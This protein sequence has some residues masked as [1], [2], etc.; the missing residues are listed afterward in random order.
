MEMRFPGYETVNWTE[1]E[2][3]RKLPE[4]WEYVPLIDVCELTMGQSPKS[5]FYN[6]NNDGLPFH[7]GVTGYGFRY[8]VDSKYCTMPTRIANEGDILCSVR[9]P[10]GR[11][12]ITMNKIIIGRG[13]SAIRNRQG[14]QS[15]QFYQL[16][17]HFY[18]EDM[19]GGGAIFNSVTK[20]VLSKQT[21]LRPSQELLISFEK[22][23]KQIDEQIQNLSI[24][25]QVLREARDILLPRLMNQTIE[26]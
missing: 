5:E 23:G 3:G 16:K 22:V 17:S 25:N 8:V 13:L 15:F 2:Q 7:Q 12:N 9:A 4:G 11:L 24:Q 20:K 6:N 10:V 21:L 1:D 14:F 19:I 18:Q 26:V